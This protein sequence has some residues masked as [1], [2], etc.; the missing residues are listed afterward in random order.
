M[1]VIRMALADVAGNASLTGK[2]Y[3][4]HVLLVADGSANVSDTRTGFGTLTFDGN[5]NYTVAGQQLVGTSSP[6]ALTGSGTYAVKPG[7][8]VTLSS[9]L[10]GGASVNARLGAGALAGSSTEAGASIFDLFIAIPAPAQAPA[11]LNGAYWISSLEFP[12]GGVSNIRGTN[13]KLTANGAGS[14]AETAVTG[15]ARNL[16]NKLQSQTVSPMT[17][18]V[19]PDGTGT[20]SFPVGAGLDATTQLIAGTKNVFVSADAAYFIGGS[21]SAGGHGMVVGVKAAAGNGSWSGFYVGAGMRYDPPAP[22]SSAGRLAAVSG[23]VNA[24]PLGAVWSRRTRQSDGLLDASTLITF[25]LTGDGSGALTSTPGSISVASGS[26]T[27]ASTGVAADSLSYELYFGARLLEQSAS[28]VF[29][30]PLGVLNAASFA[31]PGYPVSPG[32]L[33]YLYGAGLGTQTAQAASFPFPTTLAGVQVTV[34]GIAA[35]IYAVSPAR[36]DCIVPYAASG[37]TASIVATVNNTKSNTVEVP[38]SPSAPGIFSLAQN[39]LGDGAILHAN[40]SVVNANSPAKPGEVVQ[41]FLTGLGAV[42]PAVADGA[43]APGAEPLARVA[44][45]L[46]VTVGGFTANVSYQG[47]APALAGLYQLN[48]QIPTGLAAGNYSL[49]VQTIEGFT[50]MVSVR[51]SP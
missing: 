38:L 39:G 50:D 14:F 6:S 16:N 4:R 22:G 10:R 9:P 44:G 11:A 8:Y 36:I 19:S 27:F 41:V 51:V 3:F 5:G 46:R 35:P 13:F 30:N 23:A 42:S 21:A 24:T 47:L 12:N 49:A 25:S 18:S 2:Y 1:F 48:V 37:S 40:Y 31:P 26:Q 28:G 33:V 45:P 15:Q 32:G 29:L 34:N 7:G 43:A 17:Y 20:L